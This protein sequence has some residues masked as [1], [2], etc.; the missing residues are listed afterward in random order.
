MMRLN[1]L[2]VAAGLLTLILSPQPVFSQLADLRDEAA[3]ACPSGVDL[4]AYE[5]TGWCGMDPEKVV[6]MVDG[7]PTL[8]VFKEHPYVN[9]AAMP[10][11]DSSDLDWTCVEGACGGLLDSEFIE[12]RQLPDLWSSGINDSAKLRMTQDQ[13]ARAIKGRNSWLLWTGGN[14]AFWDFLARRGYGLLD[15]LKLLDNR[16]IDRQDRFR[17]LGV[18]N[19]PGMRAATHPGRFGL[20]LDVPVGWTGEWPPIPGA[21]LPEETPDPNV[22]GYSSGVMGMRL[23]P[24]PNF[25]QG[26]GAEE[27]Q[28]NW[29]PERFL[30]DLQY[31]KAPDLIRPFRVGVSCGFCH[32]SFNPIRPPVDPAEP[33]W[34]NI[35]S[36]FGAQYLKFGQL[37]GP[38]SEQ[39]NFLWHLVNF[40]KPGTVDTSLIA[41]DGINN[42]NVANGVYGLLPRIANSFHF[43]E[44]VEPDAATQPALDL[45]VL[46][47]D[48]PELPEGAQRN[49]MR[50]LA[51]GADS[52]GGRLALARVYLNIGMFHE[53]WRQKANLLIGIKPQSPFNLDELDKRSVY[54]NVTLHRMQNMA[55]FL[56]YVSGPLRLRDAPDSAAYLVTDPERLAQGREHFVTH[57]MAC[58]STKQPERFWTEP[59]NWRRWVRDP[60]YLT[61]ARTLAARRDFKSG[62]FFATDIRYPVT[63][64]GINMARFLADNGRQ[65]R[66]WHSFSSRQYKEQKPIEA[67]FTLTHPYDESKRFAYRFRDDTGPARVRPLPLNNIWATAP[68]LHNNSVGH[69]PKGHDPGDYPAQQAADLSTA[70]RIAVFNQG[71][72]ELLHLREREGYASITRT[73][74]DSSLEFPR[75]VLIDFV[76]QQLGPS[77]VT[78]IGFALAAVGLIGLA[79][80]VFGLFRLVR[81]GITSRVFAASSVLLGFFL[82]IFAANLYFKPQHSVGHIPAGTPVSLVANLNGPAWLADEARR[83]VMLQ[84]AR[85]MFLVW[86]YELPSLDHDRVPDLVDNLMAV[87][88]APDFV[89]DRGHDFGGLDIRGPD[90]SLVLPAL[91][92]MERRDL[93][94]YLRTL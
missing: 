74:V 61:E 2:F 8:T 37:M 38:D 52:V 63:D 9:I 12:G 45:S 16:Y 78:Y 46:G 13:L 50:V 58:H 93:I 3:E 69:Y 81:K 21:K 7:Q 70:G 75:V 67:A 26:P 34:E 53:Y 47:L 24:N 35:S 90:G 31:A 68:Y 60:A 64:I 49:V 18:I 92:E 39:S 59:E 23:F 15:F 72:E 54:W 76:R 56:T 4:E 17:K 20:K 30:N 1:S 5:S 42:P 28:R 6:E 51:D 88:K 55:E 80:V 79:L 85:D 40:A 66:V 89:L 82:F 25:F 77:W 84:I 41:T 83:K 10:T 48:L 57:C 87:N 22:Y 36:S 73:T 65:G 32:T 43:E 29:D 19:E 94:D 27:A 33:K 71:I 91:G 44:T 14:S 62:N 11:E 86:L